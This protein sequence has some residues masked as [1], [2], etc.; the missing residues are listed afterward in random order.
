MSLWLCLRFRQLPLECLNRSEECAV[1]VLARQRVLRRNDCAAALGIRE[2]MSTATVRALVGDE[3]LV[4]LERD[5]QKEQQCLG[6]LC[7]WAYGITPTLYQW[8][9]DCLLLEIGS[10]LN[11]HR[12]LEAIQAEVDSGLR[13]RGFRARHGLGPTP[14]SAWLLSFGGDPTPG[15]PLRERLA[16]LPLS[17][18]ATDF[19]R[20]VDSLRRA[21][22]ETLGDVLALP[23]SAL[24]R[25][26]GR[27]FSEFL[28]QVL[29]MRE[30]LQADYRPPEVFSDEYWYGYEVRANGELMPAVQ[31]L[32]QSLCRFLRNTQLRAG[33]IQWQLVGVDRK[34]RE[35]TVRGSGCHSDWESWYRLTRIRFDRLELE[36]GVE[37][38]A[39]RC[40][41]LQ[42]GELESLDLFS[43]GN[44]REPLGSLL[45]R[46]RNRL[47]LQAIEQVDCRDEHLPELALH[48]ASDEAREPP[49]AR[50]PEPRISEHCA[51]RPFWLMPSP[52][53]L[54]EHGGRLY[55]NGGAQSNGQGGSQRD[56]LRLVYGPERIED[57]W[58]REPVSR[59]YYIAEGNSG[60]RYW[61]F[62]DRLARSWHIQGVFA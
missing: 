8:R 45:D 16:P 62:R 37:G 20:T 4:L 38:L 43:P 29:G 23:P 55:W 1:T 39:L 5:P 32:L 28:Q 49:G 6:Q 9:R 14:R 61:V 51:Q 56:A 54:R 11:L 36:T 44:Q 59:D 41:R 30:D 46:L 35:V 31:L 50:T 27:E 3:P 48:S 17:L 12:G 18:L 19:Q 60:Q 47:G 42:A 22:L 34:V 57:N 2:G 13:S 26:C 7:C 21:G 52:Q 53:P 58:W 33:E 15:R 25:R 24:A 10:C 40:T